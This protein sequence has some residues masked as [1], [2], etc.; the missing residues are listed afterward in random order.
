MGANSQFLALLP[1]QSTDLN[2]LYLLFILISLVCLGG[3]LEGRRNYALAEAGRLVLTVFIIFWT[4][5]WFGEIQRS[6]IASWN[7]SLRFTLTHLALAGVS[8]PAPSG[9]HQHKGRSCLRPS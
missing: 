8:C 7:R 3:L 9:H 1:K 4:G 5:T 6:A 2:V